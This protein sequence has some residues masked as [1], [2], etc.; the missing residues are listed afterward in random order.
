MAIRDEITKRSE[1]LHDIEKAVSAYNQGQ[2]SISEVC[3]F[4]YYHVKD[5]DLLKQLQF[6]K[7]SYQ[8]YKNPDQVRINEIEEQIS[9]V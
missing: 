6:N 7:E 8:A 5:E 4:L 1:S 9:N 3:V 2:R